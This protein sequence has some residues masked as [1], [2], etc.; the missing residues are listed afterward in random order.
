[1]LVYCAPAHD[2]A[3][4]REL[5]AGMEE[6]C[7]P[8]RT[9]EVEDAP[10]V[11]LAHAAAQASTLNVGVGIDSAGNICV[12]HAKLPPEEPALTGSPPTAR[13]LGHNAAR[14]VSGKPLKLD[15]HLPKE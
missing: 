15:Q 11:S 14:L 8:S 3:G 4:R 6:E 1:V 7:V 10:A 12:H 2:P 5:Y 13:L 9:V